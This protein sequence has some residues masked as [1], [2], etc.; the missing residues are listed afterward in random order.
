MSP[1][2]P[3]NPD[4]GLSFIELV[5]LQEFAWYKYTVRNIYADIFKITYFTV[6]KY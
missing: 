1:P 6:C 2:W 5:L 4:E 3:S